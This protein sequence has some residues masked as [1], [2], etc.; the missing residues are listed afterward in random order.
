[1]AW[2]GKLLGG[3]VGGMVGGPVGMGVGAALGHYLADGEGAARGRELVLVRLEW[4]HHAFGPAGP[5]VL[6]TPVW[7]ARGHR[8]RDVRVRLYADVDR[9]EATVAP[10]GVEETCALPDFFAPYARFDGRARVTLRSDRA[11]DDAEFHVRLP[12]EVRRLGLS[13]PARLVMALVA[14]ARAGDRPLTRDD[15]RFV[16]ETFTAAHPLD[17]DGLTWLRTWLRELRD[18]DLERLSPEKVGERLA[19]HLRGPEDAEETLLWLMRGARSAWP[20]DAQE[21]WIAGLGA[22]LGIDDARLAALW[23]ELDAVPAEADR[24]RARAVL[25]VGPQASDDEIRAAWLRLVRDAHPDRARGPDAAADATRRT[26]EING[27]Y[28]LLRGG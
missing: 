22:A 14:C 16:R 11:H 5:G 21:D 19:R 26:A 23:D 6:L 27:A 2:S 15:V 28:R 18:A 24:A 12:T 20:G 4:R 8:G 25:G 17:A 13:G 3:L 9:F 1:M 7:L 10:E